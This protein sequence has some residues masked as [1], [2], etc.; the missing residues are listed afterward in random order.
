MIVD[1]YRDQTPYTKVLESGEHVVVDPETTIQRVV[2]I[3]YGLINL[4]ALFGIPTAFSAKKVGFWLA[5]LTPG[6]VY[7]PIPLILILFRKKIAKA[8]A[9]GSELS[10]FFSIITTAIRRNGGKLWAA[11]FWDAAKPSVWGA[12]YGANTGETNPASSTPWTDKHVE[13]VRRTVSAC[14]IFLLFPLWHLNNGGVGSVSTSQGASLTTNGAPNDLLNNINP[15]VIIIATPLLTHVVYPFL[16]YHKIH[17]GRVKRLTVGFTLAWISGILGALLQWRVYETSPCGYHAT[18]CDIGDGVSPLS[19]WWQ[20][21]NVALGALSECFCFVT[22]YE[23]A[24]ARAP[25][26]MKAMVTSMLLFSNA[27][28]SALGLIITPTIADPNLIWVWA[29]PA[30]AL[31]A[32]T[33]WFQWRY[34]DLEHDEFMVYRDDE[35][36]DRKVVL[37]KEEA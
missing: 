13:E 21:P 25:K 22:A 12:R 32:Q 36:E 24:Y 5:F 1:Q 35:E 33:C 26:N 3:F 31:F 23:L 16:N 9:K 20:V 27:L 4:G 10:R 11:N 6:I 19:V 29:G 15:L 34:R 18:A 8:P 30:V 28:A 14:Q 17:F 7:L 2:L 37:S